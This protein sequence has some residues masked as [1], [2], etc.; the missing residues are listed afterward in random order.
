M[1]N[2]RIC[3]ISRAYHSLRQAGSKAKTDNEQTLD[4]LGACNL[5]LRQ[6]SGHGSIMRF[7]LN[8]A[9][10]VK[11]LF[12]VRRGDIILLQYPMKK[13]FTFVCRV[14]RLRGA[15]TVALIHDLGSFRSARISIRKEIDRLQQADCII[16]SNETMAGWLKDHGLQ[17]PLECLGLFDYRSNVVRQDTTE[18]LPTGEPVVVYAGALTV[19]KSTYMLQMND[20]VES[21]RLHIYGNAEKLPGLTG[22]PRVELMGFMAADEFI[23][24]VEGDFGLVWDS[25]SLDTCEGRC[26]DYLRWNSPH[27]VSF[28]LRAGLPVI[29]WRE[30]A[31]A[32]IVEQEGIGVCID[33]IREL[34]GLLA[35]LTAE[36]RAAMRR[37]VARVSQRLAT[38]CYLREALQRSIVHLEGSAT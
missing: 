30:A 17:K 1:K 32:P 18:S 3:Y 8:L 25:N 31:V 22:G 6:S 27:K 4:E 12:C 28:Y 20:M 14:A 9:G 5:G 34:N 16:A 33:S 11:Y 29:V 13:Y 15:R 21:Y 35:R 7:L 10:V 36:E 38:G 24:H 2:Y 23:A 37:N 19:W 26:G